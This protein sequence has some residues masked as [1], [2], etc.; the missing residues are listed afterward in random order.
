[1]RIDILCKPEGGQRG[2][3]VLAN[4]RQAL[5][6]LEV[7]AEVHLFCDRR[8]M[9]DYRVYVDPA[10][11]IDDIVRIAGRVPEIREIK[12]IIVERPRYLERMKEVA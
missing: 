10:L 4:V 9:I 11:V 1:M 7:R 3:R 8:K 5:E 6:E 12:S 2:E